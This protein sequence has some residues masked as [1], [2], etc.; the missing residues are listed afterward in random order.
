MQS[1]REKVTAVLDRRGPLLFD[2]LYE[3][4]DDVE[5]KASLSTLLFAMKKA[6]EIEQAGQRQPY[7]LPGQ[8][9]R[10]NAPPAA[11]PRRVTSKR[12]AKRHAA[13]MLG[14]AP[15]GCSAPAPD[16][17]AVRPVLAKNAADTQAAMD[18]YLARIAD[19]AVLGPLKAARDGARAALA[20]FDNGGAPTS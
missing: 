20:A 17:S 18:D 7:A 9:A 19:P 2:D 15:A 16:R 11:V 10:K 14:A 1:I 13:K 4:I 5:D 8:V 6:G 3:S 12:A